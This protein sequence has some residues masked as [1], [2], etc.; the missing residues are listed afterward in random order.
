MSKELVITSRETEV[1]IA[2]LEDKKLMEIHREKKTDECAVGD[3]YFG[4]VKKIIPGLNAAF[5]NI[6]D[7]KD[8][9][10]HYLDLGFHARSLNEFV[11]QVIN[12]RKKSIGNIKLEPEVEKSGKIGNIIQ[13]G[14]SILVQIAKEPISTK[15]ARLTSE[16]SLAGR[17]L[18]LVPFMDKISISQKIKNSEERNRLKGIVQSI[19][20]KRFGIIIRTVAQGKNKEELLA[21]FELLLEKWKSIIANLPHV[22]APVKVASEEDKITSI[23]RDVVNESFD[24]VHVDNK[25]LYQEIKS[26]LAAFIPEKKDIVKLYKGQ[27]PLY[28]EM[29][30]ALQI[31]SSFGKV[32]ILKHGVYLVIEHTEA[33]HVIDVN[34]GNR[35]KTGTSE[36]N[37]LRV[38]LEAAVEIARQIRLR[39]M[40]GIITIDFIDLAKTANRT[41]LYRTLQELMK[42]DK[43]KHTILPVNKF[44]VV[45]ITRQRVRATTVIETSELC[46]ACNGTGKIKSA[47]LIQEEIENM[48]EYLVGKQLEKNFT[49]TVHPFIY[50]YFTKGL[51]SKRWKWFLRFHCWVHIV[52][53]STYSVME[54]KFYNKNNDLIVFGYEG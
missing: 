40:G 18:V 36:E 14:Q 5:V 51:F 42:N 7:E 43:A 47:L 6:C 20:P 27:K 28:E 29:N 38:N 34:S 4:R 48:I 30:I 11:N 49:L 26:Y 2:L 50:A 46:P 3:I 1:Q 19:R 41:L 52:P 15:G 39:D 35:L 16:I 12:S 45:Q 44:G 37:A 22:K 17:F 31:K 8:A 25:E 23:I 24:A 53:K 54:F 33:M 32:V 13:A 9:F 21:D 10:L